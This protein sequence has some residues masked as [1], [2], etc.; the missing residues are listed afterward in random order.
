[1]VVLSTRTSVDDQTTRSRSHDGQGAYKQ[2]RQS[3]T[4]QAVPVP[5][6][7]NYGNFSPFDRQSTKK[8][9]EREKLNAPCIISVI[10][11]NDCAIGMV[12]NRRTFRHGGFRSR[13][14]A[15]IKNGWDMGDDFKRLNSIGLDENSA[16]ICV[17]CDNFSFNNFFVC[18]QY[19][20]C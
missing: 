5:V 10:T 11:V 6:S 4:S 9:T 12:L 19:L 2:L 13:S 20:T 14:R 8:Q 18:F 15:P 16:G 17:S 1:M 3:A 7:R